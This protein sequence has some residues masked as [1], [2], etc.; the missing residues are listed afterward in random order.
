ME[1][2]II[3]DLMLLEEIK[4]MSIKIISCILKRSC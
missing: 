2:D 4:D 3:G 1:I